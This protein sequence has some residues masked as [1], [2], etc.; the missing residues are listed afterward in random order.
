[1]RD[2]LTRTAGRQHTV[3]V[4]FDLLI[5]AMQNTEEADLGAQALEIASHLEQ[6]F[7]ART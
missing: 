7:R 1:M 5:P 4:V 2:G 3:D 6:G